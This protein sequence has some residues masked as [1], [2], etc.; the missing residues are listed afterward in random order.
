MFPA[1]VAQYMPLYSEIPDEFK[2]H[3]GTVWNRLF[4]DM[5]YCGLTNLE[6]KPKDGIDADKAW[7]HLRVISRSFEPKHE[8]KEAAF[9]YLASQ[10]FESATWERAK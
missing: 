6:A 3:N 4:S 10:W 2:R 1:S 5:F 7:T 9:A 8:H